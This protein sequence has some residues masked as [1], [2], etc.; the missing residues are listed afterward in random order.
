MRNNRKRLSVDIPISIHKQI[1]LVAAAHNCTMSKWIMNAVITKL[2]IEFST[3]LLK[4][5][6][7]KH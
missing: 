5:S 7:E 1:K 3:T 4:D 2:K 6:H